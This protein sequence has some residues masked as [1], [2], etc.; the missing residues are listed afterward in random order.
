ME[1]S[2]NTRH[3]TIPDSLRTQAGRRFER[4]ERLDARVI[5]GTLVFDGA[6]SGRR[7]EARLAVAG[8]PP[9][10]SH[11]DAPTWR[12]AMDTAL[13]RLERQVKRRR[14]RM[15]DRRS[16]GVAAQREPAS[17]DPVGP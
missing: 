1:I 12:A 11:G 13:D 16:R 3:C 2:I 10:V 15:I 9:L 7:V 14:R 17:V 4:I 5:A 6:P 8:G